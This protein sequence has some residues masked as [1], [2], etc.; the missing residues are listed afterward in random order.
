M[1]APL[2]MPL[3]TRLR[4]A[5]DLIWLL[6]HV[7]SP[8][9]VDALWPG[10]RE[11]NLAAIEAAFEVSGQ[12][13]GLAPIAE[14]EG[15]LE[16]GAFWARFG[17]ANMPVVLRGAAAQWPC[18]GW[19]P[20]GLAA[21]IGHEHDLLVNLSSAEMTDPH[22]VNTTEDARVSDVVQSMAEGTGKVL[23][24]SAVIERHPELMAEL[25]LGWLASLR[26]PLH[27]GTLVRLFMGGRDTDTHLHAGPASNLFVQVY[28]RKRWTIYPTVYSSTMYPERRGSPFF[29]SRL[30]PWA[31]DLERFPLSRFARGWEVTLNPGDVLFVPT[32]YWHQVG[33]LDD[34]IGVSYRWYAPTGFARS[35]LRHLLLMLLAHNPPL[36]RVRRE[37]NNFTKIYGMVR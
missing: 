19:T 28:G 17:R 15:A 26:D 21:R 31:P 37:R 35:G 24:F 14:A 23:R 16:A 6:D 1:S 13:G 5:H 18:M 29:H 11:A 10:R 12:P 9:R 2:D 34:T 3:P 33:N 32:L 8:A 25:D 22:H 20:E 30:N 36:W 7:L 4:D 27:R